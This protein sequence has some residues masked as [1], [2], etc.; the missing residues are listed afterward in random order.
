MNKK[1]FEDAAARVS[2]DASDAIVKAIEEAA[3]RSGFRVLDEQETAEFLAG[4]PSWEQQEEN[5]LAKAAAEQRIVLHE[6]EP[7]TTAILEQLWEE[8]RQ[9]TPESFPLFLQRLCGRYQHD[10]GTV[11]QAVAIAAVGAAW[12]CDHSPQGGIT[13]FQS[14]FVMWDFIRRWSGKDGPLRLLD[15]RDAL[16]PQDAGKF[17]HT[18]DRDEWSWLQEQA[19]ALLVENQTAHERVRQHWSDIVAGTPPFGLVVVDD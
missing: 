1:V 11:V 6:G 19:G 3:T 18:I 9:Q 7:E 10:Y 4:I 16:Y 5:R 2:D 12:A 13:G 17:A 8:A 15:Y 14:G